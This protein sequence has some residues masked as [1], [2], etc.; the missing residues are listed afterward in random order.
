MRRERIMEEFRHRSTEA[1]PWPT[2]REL[3]DHVGLTSSSTVQYHLNALLAE[4]R[5][6]QHHATGSRTILLPARDEP[7]GEC[8]RR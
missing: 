4:G 1:K 3:T 6:V 7:C 8:G 5:L 2:V